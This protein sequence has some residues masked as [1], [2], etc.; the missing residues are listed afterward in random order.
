LS[1]APVDAPR[2][3][4][5]GLE[6]IRTAADTLRGVTIGPLVGFGQSSDAS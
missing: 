6:A 4:L 1:D 5:V 2:S 3:S